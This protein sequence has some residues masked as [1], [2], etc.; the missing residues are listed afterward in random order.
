[1]YFENLKVNCVLFEIFPITQYYSR[2]TQY[3][4]EKLKSKAS[5]PINNLSIVTPDAMDACSEKD[6]E[7]E[8]G[9]M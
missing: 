2:R 9:K 1:M 5:G 8:R 7:G 3:I 4:F 6:M